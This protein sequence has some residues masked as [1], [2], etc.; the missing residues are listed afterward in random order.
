MAVA[1]VASA[2]LATS[3]SAAFPGRDG[4]LAFGSS[5][6][7]PECVDASDTNCGYLAY[8]IWRVRPSG[9]GQARLSRCDARANAC[10]D[11]DPAWSPD[12]RRIAFSRDAEIWVMDADG[13]DA[14]SLGVRGVEPAWSPGG[15]RIVF[16]QREGEFGI[17]TVR[18][19][20]SDLRVLTRTLED[21]APAWSRKGVIAFARFSDAGQSLMAMTPKGSSV[22]TLVGRCSCDNPDFAPD[23]RRLVYQA[24]RDPE[25]WVASSSGKQRLRLTRRGGAE[26]VWSPSGTRIAFTRPGNGSSLGD[27]FVMASDGDDARRVRYN[28]R[29][30]VGDEV[31]G[32]YGQPSWQPL[33]R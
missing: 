4:R 17:A 30:K 20:G 31:T 9:A 11:R 33:K 7:A 25:V 3:V 32:H 12:G 10:R 5:F 21:G 28:P 22:R 2:C 26:P 24:G 16:A 15:T 19:D 14:R 18:A 29:H 27:I 6:E 1:V 13:S 23:G 8:S